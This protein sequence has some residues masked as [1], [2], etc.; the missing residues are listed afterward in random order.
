MHALLRDEH[1][2]AGQ[3]RH[4]ALRPALARQRGES[5]HVLE[6]QRVAITPRRVDLERQQLQPVT[7]PALA[8]QPMARRI[9]VAP[10]EPAQ[11]PEARRIEREH[12]QVAVGA[13]DAVRLAQ[14][15]LR[16]VG[17]LERVRQQHGV[18]RVVGD[19]EIVDAADDVGVRH[20]APPGH[21]GLALRARI[22]QKRVTRPPASDLQHLDAENALERRAHEPLLV[23]DAAPAH[24][25]RQP[26]CVHLIV[27][28]CSRRTSP[29]NVRRCASTQTATRRTPSDGA[30]CAASRDR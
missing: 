22:A 17:E 8:Q 14:Q 25:C 6:R 7:Q 3:Q 12:D 16:G 15:R 10:D 26:L 2:G 11:A 9:A 21:E 29:S 1:V 27:T 19:R 24:G 23:P 20:V 28:R 18:D 30:A 5:A 13:Q 4:P